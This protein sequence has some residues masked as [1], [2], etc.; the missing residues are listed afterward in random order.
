MVVPRS[1]AAI[2]TSRPQSL[3]Q[4]T[5]D[6]IAKAIYQAVHPGFYESEIACISGDPL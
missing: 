6:Q 3:E 1:F 2:E 5:T 4:N